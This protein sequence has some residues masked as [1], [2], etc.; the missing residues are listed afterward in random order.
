MIDTRLNRFFGSRAC[1]QAKHTHDIPM[2]VVVHPRSPSPRH[3]PTVSVS[4][5]ASQVPAW[6]MPTHNPLPT[7]GRNQFRTPT[8]TSSAPA[9]RLQVYFRALLALRR[10]PF[11]SRVD[12]QPAWQIDR[13]HSPPRA[14]VR[15][16]AAL[17]P[18]REAGSGE[19]ASRPV[20]QARR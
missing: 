10:R 8:G 18:S 3:R 6:P 13:H 20:T 12:D 5:R 16:S 9:C 4:C 14:C 19:R 2:I 11:V 7:A 15:V 1:Q 17:R